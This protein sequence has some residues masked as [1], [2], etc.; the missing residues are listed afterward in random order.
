MLPWLP[1]QNVE[2]SEGNDFGNSSS[3]GSRFMGLNSTYRE[4]V[5]RGFFLRG[6]TLGCGIRTATCESLRSLYR[7][8]TSFCSPAQV[9][10]LKY[11]GG[12]SPPRV[13]GL[14]WFLGKFFQSLD[15]TLC[16][17]LPLMHVSLGDR[18]RGVTSEPLDRER[19]APRLPQTR[20]E[21]MA[22]TV[23]HRVIHP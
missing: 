5:V 22:A 3:T 15:C 16:D 17:S 13:F 4:L 2:E 8:L 19:I 18:N 10:G 12:P 20:A 21:C 1:D 14:V 7:G 6:L 11:F 23:K 9:L